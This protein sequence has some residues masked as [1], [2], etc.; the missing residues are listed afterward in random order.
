MLDFRNKLENRLVLASLKRSVNRRNKGKKNDAVFLYTL[1]IL[2]KIEELGKKH[3][4]R[5]TMIV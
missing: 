1:N 3:F 4:Q 5:A 2:G